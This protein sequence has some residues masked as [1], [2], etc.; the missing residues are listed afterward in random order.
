MYEITH[1]NTLLTYLKYRIKLLKI[2]LG[3]FDKIFSVSKIII[4]INHIVG[5]KR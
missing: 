3:Y 1:Q 4:R 2:F 5:I